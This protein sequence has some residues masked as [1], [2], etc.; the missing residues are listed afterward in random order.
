MWVAR[1]HQEPIIAQL[2]TTPGGGAIVAGSFVSVI[3]DAHRSRN[4]HQVE[5]YLGLVPCEDS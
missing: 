4:A 2:T 1:E 5:S 3:G